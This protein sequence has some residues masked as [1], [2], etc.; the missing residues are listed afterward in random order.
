M[1]ESFRLTT[2][3]QHILQQYGI[4]CNHLINCST[5]TYTFGEIII[6][7][8]K[9]NGYLF[10]VTHGKAKVGKLAPNGKNLILCFY[11]SDGLMGELELFTDQAA[12]STTVTALDSFRCIAIPLSCNYSYL[13]GNLAFTRIAASDLARKL[14]RSSTNVLES[15]LYTA[16][17]RLCRYIINAEEH[18]CFHDVMTD[19]AYS[20]GISYRHLYRMMGVLCQRGIL[21]KT[22]SGYQILSMKKLRVA[23]TPK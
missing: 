13:T 9:E 6:S 14:M 1:K 10:L 23:A 8:G 18:G 3:D 20:V 16:E 2:D 22:D 15:S 19:V 7:E 5:R 4:S 17:I 21:K 11:V 12:G